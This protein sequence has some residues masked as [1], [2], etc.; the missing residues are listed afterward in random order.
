MIEVTVI[1]DRDYANPE[2]DVSVTCTFVG[3]GL[4]ETVEG[5]WDGGRIYRFRFSPP[6]SGNW[7]YSTNCSDTANHG[8][9]NITGMFT[10]TPTTSS[11]PFKVHGWPK[12]SRDAHC[13]TYGDGDPYF[14]LGD[15]AWEITWRSMLSELMPYISDRKSKGFNALQVV[16]MSHQRIYENGITNHNGQSYYLGDRNF[17]LLNPRYFDYLDTIVRMAND[18]GIAVAIT[19]LWAAFCY[20]YSENST[21][22]FLLNHRQ[23]MLLAHYIGAR[24][25]GYNVMWIIGGDNVYN[26]DAE[27]EFWGEFAHA[28]RAAS[29][30]RH[31]TT[32]HPHGWGTSY[33]YFG[34]YV[35]W[36][37]FN[38][39]QSSH[40]AD[41]VFTYQAALQGYALQ[42][43]KP[44]LNG[45]AAYEDITNRFWEPVVDTTDPGK[46]RLT[47]R[48]VRQ[49][50]YE[51][52]LSG[53]YVGMTYGAHGI[54]QWWNDTTE[55]GSYNPRYTPLEAMLLPGSAQMGIMKNIMMQYGW[56]SMA[57]RQDL[58]MESDSGKFV[59]LSKSDRYL[60]AYVR[61][62]LKYLKLNLLEFD[63]AIQYRWIDPRNG[64]LSAARRTAWDL[65]SL[66]IEPPDTNDW[67]L[68]VQ[69]ATPPD[70][71]DTQLV[72]MPQGQ[73]K[74]PIP[75]VPSFSSRVMPNPFRGQTSIRGVAASDGDMV[76]QIRDVTGRAI[77]TR[78]RAV[79]MGEWS[80]QV[81]D[82]SAGIYSYT[83]RF[84]ASDRPAALGQGI[85]VSLGR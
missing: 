17:D 81:D 44:L 51:S 1:S 71:G 19:P 6:T 59:P 79:G 43:T 49:A 58:V 62:G 31:L 16:P 4:N 55:V 74:Q 36:M 22:R 73:P 69:A 78:E 82:L 11:D 32:C 45:E 48:D 35:D 39:Y 85:L 61:H 18:S 76:V 38:M 40:T 29:G 77:L 83:L 65:D 70:P 12:V 23:C 67:L 24:Y 25:A 28:I 80:V 46:F 66:R 68:L 47:T 64:Q 15:T 72:Q 13:L 52:V 42:P 63:T 53:A 84:E 57:P 9:Y 10:A 14:Y 37:D 41:I 8:L 50:S 56:Q 34:N 3:W 30:G 7:R 5:F 60:L 75:N 26:T 20:L 21:H 54:W 27:R 33:Q 2:E